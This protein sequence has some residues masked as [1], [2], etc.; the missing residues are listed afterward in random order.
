M[1]GYDELRYELR[2]S[3]YLAP[4]PNEGSGEVSSVR[5]DLYAAFHSVLEEQITSEAEKRHCSR[6]ETPSG[7]VMNTRTDEN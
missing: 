1:V 7:T 6:G 3:I 4:G 5:F 2:D